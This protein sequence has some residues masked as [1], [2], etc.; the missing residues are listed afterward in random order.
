MWWYYVAALKMGAGARIQEMQMDSRSW[1]RQQN[2]LFPEAS[3]RD[4]A[5][6]IPWFNPMK[7]MFDFWPIDF[8]DD[9]F[10]LF[11]ASKFVAIYHSNN[12]ETNILVYPAPAS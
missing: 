10:L 9:I 1:K 6:F 8:W 2:T 3:K 7:P 12:T 11:S 4:A 5:L